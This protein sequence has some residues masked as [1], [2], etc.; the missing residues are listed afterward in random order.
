MIPEIQEIEKIAKNTPDSKKMVQELFE[1]Q[2]KRIDVDIMH[3][4]IQKVGV[5]KWNGDMKKN[6]TY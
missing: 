3:P 6:S 2:V 5:I 1:L 4:R